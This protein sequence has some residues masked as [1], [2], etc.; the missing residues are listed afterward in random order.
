MEDHPLSLD[1]VVEDG[2]AAAAAG[3][4]RRAALIWRLCPLRV[5]S[6]N[7]L[8]LWLEELAVASALALATW[9]A[10]RG[11][12]AAAAVSYTHLTLPTIPLV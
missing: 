4:D 7:W 10:A 8:A 6:S 12:R 1:G 11:G 5:I 9:L 2:D 3:G